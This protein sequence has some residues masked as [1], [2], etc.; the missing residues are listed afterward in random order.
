MVSFIIAAYNCEKYI[1]K[2][3]QS[4]LRQEYASFEIIVIN[5]GSTDSTRT[6]LEDYTK[7]D[8][9]IRLFNIENSGPSRARNVGL[10]NA[11][12]E[13]VIF[14][15]ADDWIE[16][17]MLSKLDI[18]GNSSPD[19]IFWGFSRCYENCKIE[20]CSPK[21]VNLT[22]DRDVVYSQLA[23]LFDSKEEFFGYSWNKLFKRSIIEK[24][25][26]RFCDGLFC[27]EDELFTL[28]YCCHI[29]S[30][31]II[32][33]PL[34]N[35]RMINSSLSHGN[36]VKYKNY[37]LLASMERECLS[38]IRHLCF[39]DTLV[40]RIFKYYVYSI[41]ECTYLKHKE[42]NS[43][44]S[45]AILFYDQHHRTL[46]IPKWQRRIFNF[47]IKSIRSVLIYLIFQIRTISKVGRNS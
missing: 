11:S 46:N 43:A 7:R 25:N 40:A 3:I 45:D 12:G 47:P 16:Y 30:L 13:W 37:R 36:S 9:R 24:A 33:L 28:M 8:A 10:D 42:L 2:C 20:I 19:I 6:I 44:I 41:S 1:S 18:T 4:I 29:S 34:Y 17:D 31:C 39:Y 35:Y 14:I 5:D 22:T 32:S 38:S 27:R 26:L 21:D 23:Y 15:D